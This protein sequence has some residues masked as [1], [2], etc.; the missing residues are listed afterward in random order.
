[1]SRAKYQLEDF[2][3]TVADDCR[4]HVTTVH[5]LLL[6]NGYKPKIGVTKS[7]GLQLSYSQP[8]IK[9]VAGIILIFFLRNDR[10][11]IRISG[12]NHKAYLDAL[13]DLPESMTS[14]ID[15]A[16]NC[17]KFADPNKCWKGCIGF[18]FHIGEKHYQ[19]CVINCF[20]FY[21]DAESMPHLL[22]IIKGEIGE[23][24]VEQEEQTTSQKNG[25]D[26]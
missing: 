21:A 20:Q 14:Q 11:T 22:E 18:D 19:K 3:T 6:Q 25:Q 8:K 7:T 24:R 4:A 26:L 5:E 10:L 23:R 9:T 16:D 2:L 12:N 1:M 17:M 15:K 13:N